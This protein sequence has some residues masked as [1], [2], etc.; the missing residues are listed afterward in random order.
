[1][2]DHERIMDEIDNAIRL[3]PDA[4][5]INFMQGIEMAMDSRIRKCEERLRRARD[6]LEEA[7]KPH[8]RPK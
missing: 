1:M 8:R 3:L 5:A 7:G 2:S 4:N 6:G